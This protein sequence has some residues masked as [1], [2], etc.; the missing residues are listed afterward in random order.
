[1]QSAPL[2]ASSFVNE[3]DEHFR[4]DDG[5]VSSVTTVTSTATSG[6]ATVGSAVQPATREGAAGA[7]SHTTLADESVSAA[8]PTAPANV[9]AST[10]GSSVGNGTDMPERASA[11]SSVTSRTEA[12]VTSLAQ[13][14]SAPGGT[15]TSDGLARTTV[16]AVPLG[17]SITP[18]AASGPVASGG[19]D[20]KLVPAAAIN[21]SKAPAAV[22]A[23]T[24]ALEAKPE[25]SSAGAQAAV[26]VVS[27]ETGAD[28]LV[29]A[30][31]AHIPSLATAPAHD[32]E[33]TTARPTPA[34]PVA[35][36]S[37]SLPSSPAQPAPVP[38]PAA[39]PSLAGAPT[40]APRSMSEPKTQ[41]VGPSAERA[42]SQPAP[43]A[44]ALLPA[45][46]LE[47]QIDS[48]SIVEPALASPIRAAT[49]TSGVE[50]LAPLSRPE[51][52]FSQAMMRALHHGQIKLRFIVLPDG[53]V[54]DP[55][56]VASSNEGLNHSA[57]IAVAQWRFAPIRRAQLGEV[58]LGF[59]LD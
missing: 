51:P 14:Q 21:D 2:T 36:P 40:E 37:V 8:A 55:S 3:T 42:I 12:S 22:A 5:A 53:S 28:T 23:T 30:P 7:Q 52:Q 39:L 13:S 50:A 33:P 10:Q 20:H 59:D 4:P 9:V 45:P 41:T 31:D 44:P 57:L 58:E 27:V 29:A 43:V 19:T 38:L 56:V 6:S 16:P 48:R 47:A 34:Q 15:E 1:V 46:V 17:A 25:E 49:D 24:N 32:P 54:S 35:L 11:D 26:P 18:A